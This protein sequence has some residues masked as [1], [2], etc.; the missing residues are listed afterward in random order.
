MAELTDTAGTP[1]WAPFYFG[2]YTCASCLG[3]SSGR[4]R[5][6]R[7]LKVPMFADPAETVVIIP[8]GR[9]AFHPKCLAELYTGVARRSA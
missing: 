4:E 9:Q 2:F 3:A 7:R 6:T 8:Q 5:R 1:Y